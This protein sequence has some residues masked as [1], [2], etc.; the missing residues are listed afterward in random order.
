MTSLLRNMSALDRN[1]YFLDQLKR[2]Y[3]HERARSERL[4]LTSARS[5]DPY[6]I[7]RLV[8]DKLGYIRE[9]EQV[10]IIATPTPT[11]SAP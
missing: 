4:E 10:I 8:R 6:E 1:Q 3:L 2:E 11:P 7:E 9:G 5:R